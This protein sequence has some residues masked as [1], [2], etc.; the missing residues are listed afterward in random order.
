MDAGKADMRN[1]ESSARSCCGVIIFFSLSAIAISFVASYFSP[2]HNMEDAAPLG[3]GLGI[4][5]VLGC[6]FGLLWAL[7]FLPKLIR[8]LFVWLWSD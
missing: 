6:G 7:V 1:A 5:L 4:A 3:I 8:K 2:I